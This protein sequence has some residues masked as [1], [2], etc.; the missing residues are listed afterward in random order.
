[1]GWQDGHGGSFGGGSWNGPGMGT[2]GGGGFNGGGGNWGSNSGGG[3]G[4]GSGAPRG[5]GLTTGSTWY[6]NTA[7]GQPGGMAQ[8]YGTRMPGGSLANLRNLAGQSFSQPQQR[9][10]SLPS[11][12]GYATP[13]MQQPIPPSPVIGALPPPAA[14]PPVAR[15]YVGIPPS[16]TPGP[17]SWDKAYRNMLN[18]TAYMQHTQSL[19][20]QPNA[21]VSTYASMPALRTTAGQRTYGVNEYGGLSGGA[22]SAGSGKDQSRVPG[23]Y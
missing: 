15:P 17:V 7:F 4:S 13:V 20:G 21:R 11:P 14:M 9:T 2:M 6:G 19:A 12:G 23:G 3:T 8:G 22:W 18:P 5:T 16:V 1:M 10:P